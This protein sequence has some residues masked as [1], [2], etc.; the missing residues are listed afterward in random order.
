MKPRD[1]S[2]IDPI[3]HLAGMTGEGVTGYVENMEAAGQRELVA[4]TVLP[5]VTDQERV[6]FEALGFEF[7]EATDD[8]FQE[9]TLPEGWSRE[10]SGHAMWSYVLDA[11]GYR[12]VAVFYKAAFYDRK[13]DMHLIRVPETRAQAEA[14]DQ[15]VLGL[16]GADWSKEAEERDGPN[17]LV[18]YVEKVRDED[19]RHIFVH[20]AYDKGLVPWKLT[21]KVR[22]FLIASDGKIV[23]DRTYTRD[24]VDPSC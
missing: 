15:I 16:S 21:G 4:S 6:Q 17:L 3:V 24:G 11:D 23:R 8:L 1:T 22:E 20:E 13:A 7:G 2:R 18:R 5:R 19:G 14:H 12:R 9:V 10:G